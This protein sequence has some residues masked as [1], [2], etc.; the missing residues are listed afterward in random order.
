MTPAVRQIVLLS[1]LDPSAKAIIAA[2]TTAP[3]GARKAA[4][5]TLVKSLKAGGVWDK[6][7]SLYILAAAD[8]QAALLDW[9][10]LG[11]SATV[12]NAPTFTA[13]RGYTFDGSTNY[14]DTAFTPS[15]QG[16]NMT[17]STGTW[18]VWERTS[19][20]VASTYH[21]GQGSG[22]VNHR[23][24][25]GPR[26]TGDVVGGGVQ[27]SLAATIGSAKTSSIGLSAVSLSSTTVSTHWQGANLGTTASVTSGGTTNVSL[28]IGGHNIAGVLNTPRAASVAACFAGSLQT[29]ALHAAAYAAL[30]AY[31][32]AVGA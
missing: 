5:N 30:Q 4:I 19:L 23:T 6:L 18:A 16:V 20:A 14:L 2:M 3:S 29:D 22:G 26:R 1:A 21:G 12:T 15:T 17:G 24:L 7:D 8:S 28:W 27:S 32:T 11:T 9:K 10:R 25:L 13:D 31:M